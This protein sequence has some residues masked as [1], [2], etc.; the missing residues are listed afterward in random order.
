MGMEMAGSILALALSVLKFSIAL[1]RMPGKIAIRQRLWHT[2]G[3]SQTQ[4]GRCEDQKMCHKCLL[5]QKLHIRCANRLA[6]K[7]KRNN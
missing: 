2:H 6:K 3:V 5:L 4:N 1:A 7:R